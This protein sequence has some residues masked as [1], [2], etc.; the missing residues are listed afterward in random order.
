MTTSPSSTIRRA[1]WVINRGCTEIASDAEL[2]NPD[3]IAAH[4]A[5]GFTETSRTVNFRKRLRS[6]ST[7]QG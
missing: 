3:S 4:A 2:D 5:L 1:I 7:E 6:R